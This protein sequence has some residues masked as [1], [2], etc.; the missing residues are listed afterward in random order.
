[1]ISGVWFPDKRM[2]LPYT[3]KQWAELYRIEMWQGIWEYKS[4]IPKRT[5]KAKIKN[6]TRKYILGVI[7][8]TGLDIEEVGC[9]VLL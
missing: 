8:Y 4:C 2:G 3:R 9:Y 7:E 5:P 6:Q 1:M